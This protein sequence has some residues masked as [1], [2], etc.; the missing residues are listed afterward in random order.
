MSFLP[1]GREGG[2]GREEGEEK[3]GKRICAEI[4]RVV[5]FSSV[6][7]E[8]GKPKSRK[9]IEFPKAVLRLAKLSWNPDLSETKLAATE[10]CCLLRISNT[11][12]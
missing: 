1:L 4:S 3:R 5:G 11:I 9:G 6:T 7:E 10:P 12:H 2:G 8:M